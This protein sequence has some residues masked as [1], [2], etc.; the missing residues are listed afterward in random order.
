MNAY[1][2]V[3]ENRFVVDKIFDGSEITT[4]WV[5]CSPDV[6]NRFAPFITNIPENLINVGD[7]MNEED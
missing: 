1:I 6:V 5:T 2:V 3:D 4:V 7:K